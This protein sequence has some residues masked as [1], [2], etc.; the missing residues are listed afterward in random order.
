V[1]DARP[2]DA[3]APARRSERPLPPADAGVPQLRD[4]MRPDVM[5]V[6]LGRCLRGGAQLEDVRV[7][8]A[9]YRPGMGA[10]VAYDVAVDGGH[11]VAV[12]AAGHALCPGAA[13]TDARRAIARALWAD[14]PV[15]RPLT[16]DVG[17][18]AVVQWYPLDLAMPVLARPMPELLRLAARAGVAIDPAT[19]AETLG[20]RPGLRAVLRTGSVVL[21]AYGDDAAFRAGVDG[22]RIASGLGLD[23]APRLHGALADLRLTVQPAID[24]VPVERMAAGTVAPVAGA[25]LRVLHDAPVRGLPIAS[26]RTAL[27]GAAAAAELV[28]AVAP[29]LAAPVR[30]LLARLEEHAPAPGTLVPSHGD[31]NVSQML[32][33]GGALAVL[34]FDDACIAPPALDLASYAANLVSGRPGDLA[35]ADAALAA[36]LDG[37]GERP[38]DLDWHFAVALLRRTASPFRLCKRRWPQRMAAIVGA[39]EEV[40]GR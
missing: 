34:D 25:M 12:A 16:Y 7:T 27:A 23:A 24:G 38:A 35:H 17:L 19:P 6:E 22:L 33:V 18:G 8:L 1:S 4:L 30:G 11:H 28:A 9:D 2:A 31:F 13:R 40:L 32:D 20:Y 15:A 26:S 5:A 36:L 29:P 39:V 10:T 14:S 21:K 3:P 37:Y